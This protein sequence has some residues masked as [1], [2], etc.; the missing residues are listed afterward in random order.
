MLPSVGFTDASFLHA[1]KK[2][3]NRAKAIIVLVTGGILLGWIN[4]KHFK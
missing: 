2:N 3:I 1:V 4:L